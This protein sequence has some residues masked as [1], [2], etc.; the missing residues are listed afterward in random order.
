MGDGSRQRF[1]CLAGGKKN[2]IKFQASDFFFL[3]ETFWRFWLFL[4]R[5]TTDLE[6]NL[7]SSQH[8]GG[9]NQMKLKCQLFFFLVGDNFISSEDLSP[10][11][12]TES[13][14]ISYWG[15]QT[16]LAYNLKTCYP[17]NIGPRCLSQCVFVHYHGTHAWFNINFSNPVKG[18]S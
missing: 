16:Q 8:V 4:D 17:K 9:K 13:G 7:L 5:K 1:L 3:S 14:L 12:Y 6:K 15:L 2:K 10:I 11:E 18:P